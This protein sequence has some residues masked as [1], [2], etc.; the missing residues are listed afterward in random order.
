VRR[1]DDAIRGDLRISVPHIMQ[2]SFF[3]M[4]CDFA[5]AHPEVR[6]QVHFSTRHVDLRP[7]CYDAAIRATTAIEPGPVART[8][9]R[10]RHRR[11]L[12]PVPRGAQDPANAARFAPPPLPHGFTPAELPQ[13]YWR[14]PAARSFKSRAS[15]FPTKSC[16][17]C[18]GGGLGIVFVPA[19][20]PG[21]ILESGA[22]VQVLPD[23]LE[24]DSRIAIVYP[25]RE[26]VPPQ[27]RAFVDTV[28]A[29][30]PKVLGELVAP[31]LRSRM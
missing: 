15:S 18:R 19:I 17:P 9:A 30:G 6:P 11:G 5:K 14:C 7:E 16:S 3:G 1:T 23:L 12:A 2:P 24:V 13:T 20:A 31:K 10:A 8:L 27:L 21:T 28:V 4:L 26:F 22:L 25:E 29:R